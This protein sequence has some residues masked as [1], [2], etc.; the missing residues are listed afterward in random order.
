MAEVFL[1]RSAG[2]GGF[3]RH[4]VL[5]FLRAERAEQLGM[6]EELLGEARLVASL[7]HHNIVQVHDVGREDGKY[8]F[9]M[10]YVH[11]EDCRALLRKVKDNKDKVPL[12]HIVTIVTSAA[13]GL[14]HAHEQRGADRKPLN[15]VHRDISPG[16]IL[17]GFDGS[18]KVADFGIAKTDVQSANTQAGEVKG[19]AGYMA[20]EQCKVMP[21]DRRTDVY[22]LGIVLYELCTVRRLF[23]AES[24]FATMQQ[25]VEG[26]IPPPSRFRRDLPD[27]L[28]RI[29]KKALATDPADRYQT[30]D[31]LRVVLEAFATR[32]NL[33]ISPSRLSDYVKDLFGERSE[34]W[35]E[36][37]DPDDPHELPTAMMSASQAAQVFAFDEAEGAHTARPSAPSIA[38]IPASQP[39]PVLPVAVAK[40]AAP[41]RSRT[42]SAAEG[43]PSTGTGKTPMA[44][45]V[46]EHYTGR[47]KRTL[48]WATVIGS[49]GA[50]AAVM[51][52]VV[53]PR[54]RDD[55]AEIDERAP[56]PSV[57]PAAAATFIA[58]VD[59]AVEQPREES[60]AT[61]PAPDASVDVVE[62]TPTPAET[63]T[64][65]PPPPVKKHKKRSR[66]RG[67]PRP[68]AATQAPASEAP[69]SDEP[70]PETPSPS[71][72]P[73]PAT[74]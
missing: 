6:G 33:Q 57:A 19:K 53:W 47:R 63:V 69:A 73:P 36:T 3:E 41:P 72:P 54:V 22:M 32:A 45:P 43:E 23:K 20:P 56:A 14:H 10:E 35:L 25:I 44:W 70:A 16:N 34:P 64:A 30:A 31:E 68:A 74:D 52:L 55:L 48:I 13:A 7:H 50:L 49:V 17:I 38:L 26:N 21:L 29:V 27:E 59:G 28:E 65:P 5:K 9:A 4:V 2:L 11:G 37:P 62:P 24:K 66:R 15:I 39:S 60:V 8:F 12:A 61:T 71:E 42:P 40:V 51:L 46:E 1:A 58:V 18:V 67:K